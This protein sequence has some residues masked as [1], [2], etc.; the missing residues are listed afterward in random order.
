VKLTA[1]LPEAPPIG[2][3]AAAWTLGFG[4]LLA[5]PALHWPMV[6]DDLH[7][8]RR[9]AF[10]ELL[11]AFHGN[12][13]PDGIETP[14]LRPL[15]LAF[16]HAR[17]LAFGENVVAHRVA[18]LALLA[19][20]LA[21]LVRIAVDL[22]MAPWSALAGVTLGLASRYNAYR[23]VWLTEG[24]HALQGLLFGIAASWLVA[25]VRA[26]RQGRVA[27]ASLVAVVA[28]LVREDSLCVLPVLV[29]LG[30]AARP[31][32]LRPLLLASLGLAAAAF[33]MLLWRSVTVPR[34]PAPGL[35]LAALPPVFARTFLL[36]GV[37]VPAG[38]LGIAVWSWWLLLGVLITGAFA[39]G[40]RRSLKAARLWAMACLF[41]CLP[42]LNMTRADIFFFA[43]F[44]AGLALA[45]LVESLFVGGGLRRAVALVALSWGVLAGS[46]TSRAFAENFHPNSSTAVWLNGI[47]VFG[48]A[49]DRATIPEARAREV[50]RQL[51][52][53]GIHS[54]SQL[55]R[56][57][58]KL[59]AQA[60]SEGRRRPTLPEILFVPRLRRL[61]S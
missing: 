1:A 15:T 60:L 55:E 35:G 61:W 4:L 31:A 17:Y 26:G 48:P 41:A 11:Q 14:G 29:L 16:N 12:W 37:E 59:E 53:V 10:G 44:F 27:A 5:W 58:P 7:L 19:G 36:T 56:K 21:L 40:C 38:A 45:A 9:F 18:V 3:I 47:F 54:R 57:L 13:D 6:Y 2:A 51:A 46:W 20:F 22:G 34:A 23:Y 30:L 8:L 33:A 49:A 42:A 24:V 28:L 25:G 43:N 32:R 50:R 39:F 52:A